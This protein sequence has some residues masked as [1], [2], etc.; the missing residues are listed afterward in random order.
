MGPGIPELTSL[1]HFLRDS[2]R[3]ASSMP[4]QPVSIGARNQH[5]GGLRESPRV[6]FDNAGILWIGGELGSTYP[7]VLPGI[8]HSVIHAPELFQ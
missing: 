3:A 1:V 5:A 2:G 8:Q 4:I 7:Q 6:A